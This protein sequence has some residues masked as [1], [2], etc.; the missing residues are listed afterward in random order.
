MYGWEGMTET[1][2]KLSL[3]GI[4]I[5]PT[6]FSRLSHKVTVKKK[7]WLKFWEWKNNAL[8]ALSSLDKVESGCQFE[9]SNLNIEGQAYWSIGFEVFSQTMDRMEILK[10]AIETISRQRDVIS[11]FQESYFS[12]A[13]NASY[14]E[15]LFHHHESYR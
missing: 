11:L 6:E 12:N 8:I 5:Q 1:W 13:L 14:P 2:E 3:G 7:R 10:E 4:P 9:I 15:L